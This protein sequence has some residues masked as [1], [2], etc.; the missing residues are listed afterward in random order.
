MVNVS[1][2]KKNEYGHHLLD[3]SLRSV[4]VCM[5]TLVCTT[6]RQTHT[7][8]DSQC[9]LGE[10]FGNM[11]WGKKGREEGK[12][13]SKQLTEETCNRAEVIKETIKQEEETIF[14]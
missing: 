14:I 9:A 5:C 13:R 6:L 7:H 8:A 12:K 1:R 2:G 3:L 10:G 11:E 4:H